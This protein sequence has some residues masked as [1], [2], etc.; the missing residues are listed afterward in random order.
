MGNERQLTVLALLLTL[1]PEADP[2]EEKAHVTCVPQQQKQVQ[3]LLFLPQP[4]LVGSCLTKL[5]AYLQS[6]DHIRFVVCQGHLFH[7][8]DGV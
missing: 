1:F 3:M 5:C 4:S 6:S 7:I 2:T 8:P